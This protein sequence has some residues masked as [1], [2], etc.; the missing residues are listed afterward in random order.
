[1]ADATVIPGSVAA[2]QFQSIGA[3]HCQE[4]VDLDMQKV[5]AANKVDLPGWS[6]GKLAPVFQQCQAFPMRKT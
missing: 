5:P 6:N 4:F 2:K 3:C 1:M